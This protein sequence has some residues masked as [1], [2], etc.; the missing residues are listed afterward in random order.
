[1]T[2]SLSR[3]QCTEI[4][5]WNKCQTIKI[6][7]STRTGDDDDNARETV[8]AKLQKTKAQHVNMIKGSLC[9]HVQF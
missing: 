5:R 3:N 9:S 6:A 8:I 1:M 4:K 2:L 7:E